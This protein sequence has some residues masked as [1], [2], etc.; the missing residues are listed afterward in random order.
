MGKR[1]ADKTA[2]RRPGALLAALPAP[3]GRVRFAAFFAVLLALAGWAFAGCAPAPASDAFVDTVF[4]TYPQLAGKSWTKD[5]VARVV[6][7]DTYET[8]GGQ[9]VRLIGVNA[10]ELKGEERE[11]GEAAREFARVRL[12]GKAVYQFRD[13][14]DT[15]RYGRLLRYV[16]VAG[17]LVMFNETLLREGYAG[18]MT[19]PPDVTFAEK[20]LELERQARESGRGLWGGDAGENSGGPGAGGEASD[21]S[22]ANPRI[23]GN[24]N[25]RGEKIYHLPGGQY[26]DITIA[27]RWFCTEEEAQ[28]AG[29]RRAA[30]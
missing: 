30:R 13:V 6:D 18:V 24:I 3:A 11:L 25:S 4:K 14:S 15:D 19:V 27:E 29:F 9:R 20:F 21:A 17:D 1:T 23:K 12:E 16:F 26:Y 28:A 5:T 22:C 7:G 8:A 2:G 10:P